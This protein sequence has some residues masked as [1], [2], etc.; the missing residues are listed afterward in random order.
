MNFLLHLVADLFSGNSTR[1]LDA[2]AALD[3]APTNLSARRYRKAALCFFLFAA[4][5]L[6]TASLIDTIAGALP[7]RNAFGW[8]G[9]CGWSGVVCLQASMLCVLRYRTTNKRT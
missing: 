7:A 2:I 6:L 4:F 8:S 9:V 1:R 5:L 3:S